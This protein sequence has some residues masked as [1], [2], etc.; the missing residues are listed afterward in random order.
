MTSP[1]QEQSNRR[2]GWHPA[3][4]RI[5]GLAVL[6]LLILAGAAVSASLNAPAPA[7]DSSWRLDYTLNRS[8]VPA[9]V[10]YRSLTLKIRVG[11]VSHLKAET[12]AGTISHIYDP[13]TGLALVTTDAATLTLRLTTNSPDPNLLG[14]VTVA[15]VMGDKLWAYSLTTDD[16][17]MS[18]Y[19]SMLGI[20]NRYGYR[21][22]VAVIGSRIGKTV[23]DVRFMGAA[24]LQA[25]VNAGWGMTNHTYSHY[26][27][28]NPTPAVTPPPVPT[29]YANNNAALQDILRNN[30]V[31]SNTLG[32]YQTHVFTAPFGD[33]GFWP[34]LQPNRSTTGLYIL[35]HTGENIT[36]VDNPPFVTSDY[37]FIIGRDH[38]E[39]AFYDEAHNAATWHGKHV[40]LNQHVHD[41]AR[42]PVCNAIEIGTDYLYYHYGAGGTDEVWVAPVE[43]VFDYL[44]TRAVMIKTPASISLTAA[45]QENPPGPLPTPNITPT[46]TP[47]PRLYTETFH[48]SADT[49]L[50]IDE[51]LRNF[52]DAFNVRVSTKSRYINIRAAPI[53]FDLSSLSEKNAIV[54]SAT[55]RLF[56]IDK[57]NDSWLCLDLYK[58]NHDW[59][60]AEANW[61]YAWDGERW[62]SSGAN[63]VPADREG[64]LAT[65]RCWVSWL[66]HWYQ[67][68]A[69]SLARDWV[70]A[71]AKNYGAIVKASGPS[72]VEYQFVSKEAP[73]QN[74]EL[75]VTYA[76]PV[77]APT[78]TPTPT[79]EYL[80]P[81][82][83][84]VLS[85]TDTTGYAYGVRARG[86]FA[87]VA[88]GPNGNLKIIDARTPSAP[89]MIGKPAGTSGG[90]IAHSV[91]LTG[92]LAVTGERTGYMHLYDITNPLLAR[93]I[94]KFTTTGS[95]KGV[96]VY[97]N[98]AYIA[99]EWEGLRIVNIANPR[100][101]VLLSS[102]TGGG[103]FTEA[104]DAD[105]QYAYVAAG[106]GGL[107]IVNVKNSYAP[108]FVS[109]V[110]LPGYAYAVQLVGNLV[111][112]ACD[113]GE[114]PS[115]AGGLQI[116][117]VTNR[118]APRIVGS[119]QAQTPIL[120]VW[121]A[122]NK[123]YLAAYDGGLLVLDVYYPGA[124]V[125]IGEADTPGHA[126]GVHVEN[127]LAYVADGDAG[128][129]I[130]DV[131]PVPT[132]TPTPSPTITPEH[133]PTP[134]N[135]LTP[136]HTP[137]ATPTATPSAT[138]TPEPTATP[139]ATPTEMPTATPT[140]THTP[141]PTATNTPTPTATPT[142]TPR[143]LYRL[144]FPFLRVGARGGS[145]AQV[146][147][148][149][150]PDRL[151]AQAGLYGSES[152]RFGVGVSQI[153]GRITDYDVA[154]LHIG[155]YSDWSWQVNPPHPAHLDYVNVISVHH[156]S[157][158]PNWNRLAQAIAANPGSL[159]IVGNEPE[160]V[161]Q[162][163][164]TPAEYAQIYGE[165]YDFI[166][167]QDATAL[168]AIGGVIE[169]TPLRLQ[170][171]DQVR[172][173]YQTR[174]GK[175]MPVDVWNI[176]VQILREKGPFSGCGDCW[177]AGV[178]AGLTGVTEGRLY[179]FADN[180]DPAIFRQLVREFRQW[181][182]DRG[183]R[184]KPL[185]IS[186]YGVLMP[187]DYLASTVEEGDALVRQF[188]TETFD[189]LRT[190]TDAALGYPADGNRLVQRW[191]WYSL[192]DS[193]ANFNGGLFRHDNPAQITTFGEHFRQYTA[194]LETP[195]SDL[196]VRSFSLSP[197]LLRSTPATLTARAEIV[198]LGTEDTG[199]FTVAFYEGNPNISGVLKATVPFTGAK[200]RYEE[201]PL[202]AQ[203]SWLTAK[204]TPG[205]RRTIYAV[206]DS[207]GSVAEF[208][209]TNNMV[210][211]TL[212]GP[213][214]RYLPILM[215]P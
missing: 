46:P 123:A 171:L 35:Q 7:A 195:F 160:G 126:Y 108:Q 59:K 70:S 28:P 135:T 82:K 66:D 149:A 93:E 64:D 191:L 78:P 145:E 110:P 114:A 24:E 177:G 65:V 196:I 20:M 30:Q 84:R 27:S 169:P 188:M 1:L 139:T 212:F 210:S 97:G 23:G 40:W 142:A 8:G 87:F 36:E 120:G 88:D 48:P 91:V 76:L 122:D 163:N 125:L 150:L 184:N 19:E 128:L 155:W 133:T 37:F 98:K 131:D 158:P 112:V 121:V 140:E 106:Q 103:F 206:V 178:P 166:K 134:T 71:P 53:Q 77:G 86:G 154:S 68:N 92:N 3:L 21:G 136:T 215:R 89:E 182:K 61:D 38:V 204:A 127:G 151:S 144:W 213:Y 99:D 17:Y 18:V 194:L 13:L 159:W 143:P 45:V 180:V 115:V 85:T 55:L 168:V 170:W 147:T 117:D 57:S 31:I 63:G 153:Y 175:K 56:S 81:L 132:R 100:F 129:T 79:P 39:E 190:T 74:P 10:R 11:N 80:W 199:P 109:Q 72:S 203:A 214:R 49:T 69:T 211:K 22:S 137:T 174:Y 167:A 104:V 181:M 187:S 202:V 41:E 9:W 6:A 29:R 173:E 90:G 83:M 148:Q 50:S 101:P 146:K 205:Q 52:G 16:G 183:E 14:Q 67:M 209:E 102:L 118:A 119:Y 165:V 185:I 130:V 157:Y 95:S 172:A 197:A 113:G 207:A 2:A 33:R 200:G 186:E 96:A 152:D 201:H 34:I 62:N 42:D 32:G 4:L 12:A 208:N 47:L 162:G 75:I 198:N 44:V 51:P 138:H 73:R 43:E 25:L 179:G 193:P 176:H 58:M 60:E 116:V 164:R 5:A 26:Y 107:R 161:W 111:Y 94:K 141:A 15:P 54:I 189:F 105:A 156:G 192:N 124:T